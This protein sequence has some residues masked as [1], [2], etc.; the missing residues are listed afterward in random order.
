VNM[1][2]LAA[3]VYV[4]GPQN[5]QQGHVGTICAKIQPSTN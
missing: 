4:L 3:L 1:I 5:P 2:A